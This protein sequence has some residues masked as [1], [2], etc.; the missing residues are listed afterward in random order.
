MQGRDTAAAMR[1]PLAMIVFA[2]LVSVVGLL[3]LVYDIVAPAVGEAAVGSTN[4]SALRHI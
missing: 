4:S 1:P 2:A 3:T